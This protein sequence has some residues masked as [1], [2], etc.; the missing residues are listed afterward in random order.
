LSLPRFVGDK[1]KDVKLVFN[2]QL[3]AY[4]LEEHADVP[5]DLIVRDADGNPT[6]VRVPMEYRA[7]LYE[8]S[9]PLVTILVYAHQYIVEE[10]KDI[11]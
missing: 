11:L 9:M 6:E 3:V 7:N 1:K 5:E 4:N 10:Y 8:L 2:N